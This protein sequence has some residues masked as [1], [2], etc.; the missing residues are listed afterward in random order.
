V[1]GS[2][3]YGAGLARFL[4]AEGVRVVEVVRPDRRARRF[5]GKKKDT[6]DVEYAAR[7]VLAGECTSA[8]KHG[9]GTVE[10]LRV[11]TSAIKARRADL[12][13]CATS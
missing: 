8:P 13:L 6:L 12:Q 9:D 1:E 7:A 10:A 11:R 2:G 5:N 4:L 3:N